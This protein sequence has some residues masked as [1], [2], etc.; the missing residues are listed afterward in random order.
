VAELHRRAGASSAPTPQSVA[1]EAESRDP[2]KSSSLVHVKRPHAYSD[3]TCAQSE[4]HSHASL[5]GEDEQ[6]EQDGGSEEESGREAE[7]G[8]RGEELAEGRGC[9]AGRPRRERRR[10][11]FV[12]S[13]AALSFQWQRPENVLIFVDWDDTLLPTS[14]LAARPWF[15]AWSAEGGAAAPADVPAA[16]R[17]LLAAL[18]ATARG[19]LLAASLLGR[20][21]CVTLAARPWQSRSME[22]L[23]PRLAQLWRELGVEVCYAQEVKCR[24]SGQVPAWVLTSEDPLEHAVVREEVHVRKKKRAM[25]RLLRRCLRRSSWRNVLSFGD[26]VTE[27]TAIQELA[28]ESDAVCGEQRDLLVKTVKMYEEPDCAQ[29][30]A[31]L[32]MLTAWLPPLVSLVDDFGTIVDESEEGLLDTYQQLVELSELGGQGEAAVLS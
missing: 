22:A 16:D 25:Q 30:C 9:Q 14:W 17:E 23:L 28:F 27:Q 20:V 31:E 26:G 29:L 32:Q 8:L 7:G 3:S 10:S 15:R 11:S 2:S 1:L 24:C 5:G 6:D 4:H 19:F 13:T 18:D 12:C 21:C